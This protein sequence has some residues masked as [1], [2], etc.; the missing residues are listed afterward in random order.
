MWP[1]FNKDIGLG[2]S[3]TIVLNSLYSTKWNDWLWQ[4]KFQTHPCLIMHWISKWL[5]SISIY[6]SIHLNV[7]EVFPCFLIVFFLLFSPLILGHRNSL[8]EPRY[9]SG[10]LRRITGKLPNLRVRWYPYGIWYI[11]DKPKYSIDIPFPYKSYWF[12]PPK[13]QQ[14]C[15]LSSV[16][17]QVGHFQKGFLSAKKAFSLFQASQ[18][19]R[20]G[21]AKSM[22]AVILNHGRYGDKVIHHIHPIMGMA[23][24]EQQD[25]HAQHGWDRHDR[26]DLP[27]LWTSQGRSLKPLTQFIWFN[28][29]FEMIFFMGFW[30]IRNS[31]SSTTDGSHFKQAAAKMLLPQGGHRYLPGPRPGWV[32]I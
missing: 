1:P 28:S 15:K 16:A 29:G 31:D 14:I 25:C 23:W 21:K 27:A 3:L 4:S 8:E 2:L 18:L 7:L 13:L 24:E 17:R 19:Q 10:D 20:S 32:T 5:L 30:W 26:Q 9:D 6:I 12:K 22:W 11:I